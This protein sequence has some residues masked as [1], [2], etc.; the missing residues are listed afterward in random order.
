MHQIITHED[1]CST[2]K[3]HDQGRVLTPDGI[4]ENKTSECTNIGLLRRIRATPK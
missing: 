4:T 3:P 1:I 2:E